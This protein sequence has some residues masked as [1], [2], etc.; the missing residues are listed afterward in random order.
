LYNTESD[1]SRGET[2]MQKYVLLIGEEE[3]N[4][5]EDVIRKM[6]RSSISA[7]KP[8]KIITDYSIGW[9][10]IVLDEAVKYGVPYMGVLPYESENPKYIKLSKSTTN[11]V[12]YK[13]K[14]EFFSNP[15]PYL[16][17]LNEHISEV[18]CYINPEKHSFKNN[19]LR[20]LRS[21]HV[22]NIFY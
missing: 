10:E 6:I 9:N 2:L 19:I 21:K 14:E 5:S 17:W 20:A 3:F 11:L 7:I 18:F 22:R 16:N 1:N 15:F 13:T 12:F 4:K 8:S